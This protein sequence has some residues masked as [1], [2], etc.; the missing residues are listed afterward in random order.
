MRR[1]ARVDETQAEIVAA[2]R[3]I[4]ASVWIIGLPL[5][6]LVGYRGRTYLMEC[7]RLEGKREPKPADH[8]GLQKRFMA[9]WAGG[10]YAT[11][12]D[13]EGA[14]RAVSLDNGRISA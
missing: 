14:I 13:A 1:A 7:K 2:L 10:A 4:G 3:K 6:L 8:T 12:T 5:D 11:V 9:T